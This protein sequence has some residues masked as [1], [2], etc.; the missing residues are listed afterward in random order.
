MTYFQMDRRKYLCGA[1][2]KS[3][4]QQSKTHFPEKNVHDGS[5]PETKCRVCDKVLATYNSRKRHESIVHG[6]V[7]PFQY[8]IC[9]TT[10]S[11]QSN[12]EGHN[13]SKH[14]A[15]KLKCEHCQFA[16]CY[17][18]S[19]NKHEKKCQSQTPSVFVCNK[20][21]KHERCSISATTSEPSYINGA[22]L[23]K[24]SQTCFEQTFQ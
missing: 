11:V 2:N 20:R 1:C 23:H 24:Q 18:Y 14:G 8:E 21:F 3:F 4:A 12:L 7:K 10:F 19:L 6:S 22:T 5:V 17:E 9:D 16:F 13:R 15:E